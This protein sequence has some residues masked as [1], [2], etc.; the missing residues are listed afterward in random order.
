M[1]DKEVKKLASQ[2]YDIAIE[3]TESDAP[4][5]I[6]E[7]VVGT[8]SAAL[9]LI[10]FHEPKFKLK[11]G[12]KKAD[13]VKRMRDEQETKA[14]LLIEKSAKRLATLLKNDPKYKTS[15]FRCLQDY[16]K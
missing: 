16:D 5:E 3:L 14:T 12:V 1:A 13:V 10:R 11:P 4:K 6:R 8:N 7:I 9:K 15:E 2:V